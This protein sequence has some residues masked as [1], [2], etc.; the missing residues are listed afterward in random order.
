MSKTVCKHC[1][2]SFTCCK[3]KAGR[4]IYSQMLFAYSFYEIKLLL[5]CMK[6]YEQL[7]FENIFESGWKE[8][9]ILNYSN[10][11]L[12]VQAFREDFF[13]NTR[14]HRT[15]LVKQTNSSNPN[16]S[17]NKLV[18][19]NV[20]NEQTRLTQTRQTTNSLNQTCRIMNSS[21]YKLAKRTNSPNKWTHQTNE[22][23]EANLNYSWV[24]SAEPR[25]PFDEL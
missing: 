21:N 22:L 4:I 10:V 1:M 17:N 11:F 15:D 12:E 7:Q 6:H 5:Y 3:Q 23:V 25:A 14:T 18:E 2:F 13:G 9:V 20:S 8:Q 19:P 16:S 24:R